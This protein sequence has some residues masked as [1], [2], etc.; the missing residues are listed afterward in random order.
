MGRVGEV[1]NV[2]SSA[3]DEAVTANSADDS[4]DRHD[5]FVSN[6]TSAIHHQPAIAHGISL[7][8]SLPDYRYDQV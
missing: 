2:A 7:R 1:T 6:V 4:T 8:R 3:G 5:N